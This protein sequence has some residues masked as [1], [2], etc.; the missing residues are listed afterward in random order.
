MTPTGVPGVVETVEAN[1]ETT[2]VV[3]PARIVEACAH[4]RDAEGFNVLVDISG[5][6]YLGLGHE[7]GGGLHRHAGRP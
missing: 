4:L 6:D 7:G 1:G 3:D 5:V 2:L